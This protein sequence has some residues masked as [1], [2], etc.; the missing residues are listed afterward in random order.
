ME[1]NI[2]VEMYQTGRQMLVNT[3][4]Q[5]SYIKKIESRELQKRLSEIQS[6]IQADLMLFLELLL[7]IMNCIDDDESNLPPDNFPTIGKEN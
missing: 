3:D 2:Y 7:E 5:M 6:T 1:M 4:S